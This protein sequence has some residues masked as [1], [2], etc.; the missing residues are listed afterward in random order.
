MARFHRLSSAART[1]LFAG[2]SVA[3]LCVSAQ[4][5]AGDLSNWGNGLQI[6]GGLAGAAEQPE[7]SI[8][9]N[10]IG[11][12][13]AED[14]AVASADPTVVIER[15]IDQINTHLGKLDQDVGDL[16]QA[17]NIN[18]TQTAIQWNRDMIA[19][20][21]T[22]GETMHRL[23]DASLRPLTAPP[24]S[25]QA[26]FQT[27]EMRS[28]YRN[29]F[30][31]QAHGV[32]KSALEEAHNFLGIGFLA[33]GGCDGPT[34]LPC[35]RL[36][37]RWVSEDVAYIPH[38]D[39]NPD[40]TRHSYAMVPSNELETAYDFQPAIGMGAYFAALL[41]AVRAMEVDLG[42]RDMAQATDPMSHGY[43]DQTYAHAFDPHIAFLTY[44]PAPDD[45]KPDGQGDTDFHRYYSHT[46]R[47]LSD[48]YHAGIHFKV[49]GFEPRG[50]EDIDKMRSLL[51]YAE[52]H[53]TTRGWR[54]VRP[55]YVA[56]LLG[57]GTGSDH[58]THRM[59]GGPAFTGSDHVTNRMGAPTATGSMAAS[60]SSS[61]SAAPGS[62]FKPANP[63]TLLRNCTP[64]KNVIK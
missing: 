23:I 31:V 6:A 42:H 61:A 46:D 7:L 8:I 64:R 48:S 20:N 41:T 32:A 40:G 29:S 59:E 58:V 11:Q 24:L 57:A 16:V 63:C 35:T 30:H 36:N 2:V 34:N 12:M 37:R 38:A 25:N 60:Q 54:Y 17:N 18:V 55:D 22:S 27:V 13:M 4:V 21:S 10:G 49:A 33:L 9:L 15:E 19:D 51:V 50:W 43:F 56:E 52:A 47:S 45:P 5:G 44:H 3:G 14:D 53:G 39:I 26:N 62:T 28:V 1:A